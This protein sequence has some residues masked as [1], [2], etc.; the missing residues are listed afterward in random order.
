MK[1]YLCLLLLKIL[2]EIQ[3][4]VVTFL[5][6]VAWEMHLKRHDHRSGSGVGPLADNSSVTIYIFIYNI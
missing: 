3:Q 1:L 2:L 4:P 5:M 6:C